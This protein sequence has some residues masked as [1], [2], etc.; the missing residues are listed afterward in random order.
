MNKT[1]YEDNETNRLL[2]TL[3]EKVDRNEELTR[4]TQ[5]TVKE[6]QRVAIENSK[7]IQEA[8]RTITENSK[9]IEDIKKNWL[10]NLFFKDH[11]EKR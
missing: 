11:S 2:K 3:I 1:H 5:E 8:Q 7:G 6:A 4:E 10:I 9:G